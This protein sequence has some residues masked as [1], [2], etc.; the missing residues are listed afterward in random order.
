MKTISRLVLTL[1]LYMHVKL[2]SQESLN[3][4]AA[5]LKI[6][7]DPPLAKVVIDGQEIGSTPLRIQLKSGKKMMELQLDGYKTEKRIIRVYEN[8]I[9]S[10]QFRLKKLDVNLSIK[11]TPFDAL[12]NI[13][14][15]KYLNKNEF[16]LSSESHLF[17]FEKTGYESYR[18]HLY[19]KSGD[20]QLEIS[21]E[22]KS[23]SGAF[24]RSAVLPGWGQAYQDKHNKQYIF[25]LLFASTSIGTALSIINYNNSVDIYNSAK[26][27][28]QYSF[29][30]SDVNFYRNQME[31]SYN[32]LENAELMRKFFIISTISVWLW[33]VIDT[34][35]VPPK[36]QDEILISTNLQN[37]RISTEFKFSIR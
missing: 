2:F 19:F 21:L 3:D 32:D 15:K 20:R 28:Y 27:N 1:L 31:E 30:E 25:P 29:K 34:I 24:I 17:L 8:M 22:K 11:V 4:A 16:H 18:K 9:K 12:I 23:I 37:N 13:D 14:G 10:Y 36:W 33:N 35:I 5:T 7:S 6:E 26:F